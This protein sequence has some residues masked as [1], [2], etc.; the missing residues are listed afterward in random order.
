MFKAQGKRAALRQWPNRTITPLFLADNSMTD[1]L[2]DIEVTRLDGTAI[3]LR[4]FQGKVLLIVNTASQ[5]GFTPQYAG[6]QKLYE[7]YQSQGLEILAFP[8]NQ[9]GGQEPGGAAEIGAFCDTQYHVNFPLFAK[10]EVNG[11][12]ASPLYRF[13]KHQAKG[14]FGTEAIKWNFTKF[15]IDRKGRVIERFASTTSPESL[16]KDIERLLAQST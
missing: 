3:T 13:L 16:S 1:T 12:H 5:C 6:L 7:T 8:C 15:L 4:D 14:L 9:F 11:D 10:I 2:Y